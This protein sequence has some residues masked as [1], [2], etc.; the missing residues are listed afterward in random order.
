MPWRYDQDSE[1]AARWAKVELNIL[2]GLQE[3]DMVDVFRDI[4]GYGDLDILDVS[5]ATQTEN[6][7]TVAPADVQGKRFDHMIASREL[8]P[9]ECY[10]DHEGFRYSD[11]APLL[12]YYDI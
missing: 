9:R 6:P 1:V 5:H 7:A 12:A 3:I 8:N 2:T 11:H 10:Y 4:H